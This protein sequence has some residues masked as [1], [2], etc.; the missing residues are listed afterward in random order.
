[1]S[2]LVLA[3][4]PP[5]ARRIRHRRADRDTYLSLAA[6]CT[7]EDGRRAAAANAELVQAVIDRLTRASLRTLRRPRD[8]K[9]A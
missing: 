2:T 6:A 9:G 3:P 5:I 1:M 8:S 7:T 4:E